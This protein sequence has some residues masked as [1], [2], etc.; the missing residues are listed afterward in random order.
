[1]KRPAAYAER[2]C[3]IAGETTAAGRNSWE[4]RE[5]PKPEAAPTLPERIRAHYELP[6]GSRSSANGYCVAA[7]I[8]LIKAF[9]ADQRQY[10]QLEGNNSNEQ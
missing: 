5:H 6:P 3:L 9:Q 8:R 7:R 10:P 4:L 2:P 1:M